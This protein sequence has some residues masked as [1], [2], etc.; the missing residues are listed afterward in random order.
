LRER[1]RALAALRNP[2]RNYYRLLRSWERCIPGATFSV[3]IYNRVQLH[4]GEVVSDFLDQL[5]VR[6]DEQFTGASEHYNQSL[7]VE[8][9]LLLETLK[10]LPVWK[11]I[12]IALVDVI[13][14]LI[15]LEGQLTRYFLSESTVASIRKHYRRSN[16][17]LARHFMGS[18]AYPFEVLSP[19]WRSESLAAIA[20]RAN[21]RLEKV[22]QLMRTPTLMGEAK[23]RD[24]ASMVD[25]AMGWSTVRD[26]GVWST[27][28]ESSIRFR[29]FRHWLIQEVDC[30]RLVV[31]GRYYGHNC[32]TRVRINGIDFGEQDLTAGHFDV[33]IPVGAL[34][35][36]EVIE[37]TLEHLAPIS[38]AA[39]EGTS[40]ER[41]LA[42][43]VERVAYDL[44]KRYPAQELPSVGKLFIS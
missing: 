12:I 4:G 15:G 16:L 14:S 37:I 44:P 25:F 35:P 42:F 33:A 17:K 22:E 40:D 11:D 10:K 20:T 3:R 18:D 36:N 30:V 6:K 43:G 34:Y 32:R 28:S 8:G 19:C 41:V 21:L 13:Q 23:G 39:F 38:P 5:K 31:E 27:G 24:L 7:D 9:A 2:N 1:V 29:L 26:W